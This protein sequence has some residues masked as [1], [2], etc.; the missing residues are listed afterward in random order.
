MTRLELIMIGW[1][2]LLSCAVIIHGLKFS[3]VQRILNNM[4][5]IIAHRDQK[6]K[7]DSLMGRDND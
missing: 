5:A 6:S 3:L 1:N 4:V 7:L 2:V